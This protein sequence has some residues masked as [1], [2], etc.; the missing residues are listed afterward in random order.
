MLRIMAPRMRKILT[1]FR[2]IVVI[3]GFGA[4]LGRH[5]VDTQAPARSDVPAIAL[6]RRMRAR[7]S[8]RLQLELAQER[9]DGR[10]LV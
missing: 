3:V 7:S 1:E 10:M 5:S 8:Q 4:V 2:T 9:H 6:R